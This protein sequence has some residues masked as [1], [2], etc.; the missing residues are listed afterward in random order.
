MSRMEERNLFD[1]VPVRIGGQD[2][3]PAIVMSITTETVAWPRL[4]APELSVTLRFVDV[5]AARAAIY[6][7]LNPEQKAKLERTEKRRL[8]LDT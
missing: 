7:A 3:G 2:A 8:R 4:E 5:A 6:A 1:A